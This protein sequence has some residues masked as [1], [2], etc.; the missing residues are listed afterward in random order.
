MEQITDT[1]LEGVKEISKSDIVIQNYIKESRGTKFSKAS[2]KLLEEWKKI[3][4][5]PVD[6]SKITKV[7]QLRDKLRKSLGLDKRIPGNLKAKLRVSENDAT[8]WDY[9]YG[10]TTQLRVI[11]YY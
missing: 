4:K 6:I 5:S 11:K 10:S 9:L 7:L 8:M 3:M 1:H 2:M